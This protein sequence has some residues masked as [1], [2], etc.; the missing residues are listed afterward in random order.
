MRNSEIFCS[1]DAN[2]YFERNKKHGHSYFMDYLLEIFPKSELSGFD[3][4]E[5]GIG[6]GQNLMYLK[7]FVKKTHGYEASGKA[8]E[9]FRRQYSGHPCE[10]DFH[11]S[12]VNL[13]KPFKGRIKYDLVIYGFF[14]YYCS[15]VEMQVCKRNTLSMLKDKAYI[16]VFDFL[17]RKN[18]RKA[19]NRNRSLFVYKRNIQYWTRLLHDFDLIDMRVF[20]SESTAKYK[21]SDSLSKIDCNLP[22]NDDDWLFSG[23]FR[24][25]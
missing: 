9:M 4:A 25:K 10:E 21:A 15:D 16:Y 1:E 6:N 22:A 8:C 24:R 14:P 7:N 12:Q 13:A 18:K 20:S 5:F 2:N 3:V 23:L 11:V 19:D 17:V